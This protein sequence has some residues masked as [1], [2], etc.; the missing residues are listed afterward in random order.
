[1]ISTRKFSLAA[2]VAATVLVAALLATPKPTPPPPKPMFSCTACRNG[3]ML[4]IMGG[5]QVT[6]ACQ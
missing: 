1:M 3:V 2:L 4:C 5:R 6:I